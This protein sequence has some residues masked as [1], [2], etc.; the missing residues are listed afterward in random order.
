MTRQINP[1]FTENVRSLKKVVRRKGKIWH[2]YKTDDTWLAY[3]IVKLTCRQA[4]KEA[5]TEVISGKVLAC[6][7]DSKKLYLLFNSLTGT[8]KENPLPTIYDGN[9]EMAN[10]FADYFMD[11]IKGI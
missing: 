9:E 6:N 1:W 3:K 7:Q 5:K 8:T 4:L 2:K 10:A 11:K